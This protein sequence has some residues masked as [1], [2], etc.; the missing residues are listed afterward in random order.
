[1]EFV[2][3]KTSDDKKTTSCDIFK[4]FVFLWNDG[5]AF[6]STGADHKL[7]RVVGG[8]AGWLDK[9]FSCK[10]CFMNFIEVTILIAVVGSQLYTYKEQKS[11]EV[12]LEPGPKFTF[13]SSQ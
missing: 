7:P 8:K 9:W 6:F 4:K 13:N 1:L 10:N 3:K 12:K 5:I 11:Q 2:L